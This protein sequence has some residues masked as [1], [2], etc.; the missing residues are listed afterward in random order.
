MKWS[1][2][3]YFKIRI[4]EKILREG[5]VCQREGGE[6]EKGRREEEEEEESERA[7]P[8]SSTD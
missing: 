1:L 8:Y 5:K 2:P 3:T 4:M 6:E 7:E